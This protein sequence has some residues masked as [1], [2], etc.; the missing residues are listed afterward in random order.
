MNLLPLTHQSRSLI[1]LAPQGARPSRF[2]DVRRDPELHEN[3]LAEMQKFR[4]GV[5]VSEGNLTPADLTPDGR[6]LQA[7]DY[8]SW[9]LLTINE[10]GS[11]A[12]C[13]RLVFH[14]PDAGFSELLVSHCALAHTERWGYILRRVVEAELRSAREQCMQFAELG[15]WAIA[16]ELRCSTEAVR[17][18][19]A[20]YA[21]GQTLGGVRG[22][23]TVNTQHH[24]SS[25]LRRIGGSPL[26][27]N[28]IEVPSFYEPQY[29]AELEILR[30]DAFQPNP[31]YET[32]IQ[33]CRSAL[34]TVMV[35]SSES[36]S[37]ACETPDFTWNVT[38]CTE[39]STGMGYS[40]NFFPKAANF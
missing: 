27:M 19:L 22:I 32:Y 38:P 35:I 26:S 11:V 17:M 30:F 37:E 40:Q 10:Y 34:E 25:I 23:S 29:R 33:Q 3:I 12:A 5:Y 14:R 16:K 15:G 24:S 7:V 8:K 13:G 28:G 39:H 20:G 4:G 6:H 18:V 21:L 1:L 31:R 2:T 9:H 36:T